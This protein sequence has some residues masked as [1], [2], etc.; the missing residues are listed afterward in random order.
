MPNS[1]KRKPSVTVQGPVAKQPRNCTPIVISDDSDD[2]IRQI[3]PP[4]LTAKQKGKS[5][6]VPET[7]DPPLRLR[8]IDVISIPDDEEP[9]LPTVSRHQTPLEVPDHQLNS[10]IATSDELEASSE[11]RP[12]DQILG[13]FRDVFIGERKCSQCERPIRSIRNPVCSSPLVLLIKLTQSYRRYQQISGASQ[14]YFTCSAPIA[15]STTVVAACPPYR[16]PRHVVRS[17]NAIQSNAVL[18]LESSPFLRSLQFWI[19]TI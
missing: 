14:S 7:D 11:V 9:I 18:A 10:V 17:M 15:K 3:S 8:D 6:A 4:R 5:R 16:A 2:D 13:Q 1:R 12:P 19:P